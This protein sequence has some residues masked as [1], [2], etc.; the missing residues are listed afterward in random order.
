MLN[1]NSFE[2]QV[3]SRLLEFFHWR[4]PW[5][6]TIWT[7]GTRLLLL[8]VLEASQAVHEGVLFPATL[9]NVAHTAIVLSGQDPGTGG[10]IEKRLLHQA[11]KSD[12]AFQ[13]ME[14][15]AIEAIGQDLDRL[16][17][18]RW[19]AALQAA[20]PTYSVERTARAIG[21]HL[22]DLG[23]SADYLHRWWTYRIR[24]EPEHKSLSELVTEV[25]ELTQQH[26]GKYE[27]CAR[28]L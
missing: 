7:P 15:L 12:I 11:L 1:V 18:S 3:A 26:P 8:E 6:R 22:L 25:D 23:F 27:R 21:S 28:R 20:T 10:K 2:Q 19:A 5:H 16:Y 24:H 9:K 4:A 13:S 14:Y 17:L